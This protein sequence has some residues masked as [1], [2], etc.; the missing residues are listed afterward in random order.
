MKNSTVLGRAVSAGKFKLSAQG[1]YSCVAV[2]NYGNYTRIDFSVVFI[3][4]YCLVCDVVSFFYRIPLN[5]RTY[6]QSH[7]HRGTRGGG[8]D[9]IPLGFWYAAILPSVE[10]LWSSLQEEIYFMDGG[11]AEGLWRHQTWSPSWPPSWILSRIRNRVKTVWINNFLRL[12][13]KIT[14]KQLLCIVSSTSFTFEKSWKNMHF[15]SKMAWRLLLMTSYL[16]TIV[17]DRH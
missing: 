13:C 5:H 15:H 1:N 6:I 17:T 4:K 12:T 7:P 3:G 8:V 14:H 10:S 16:V 11:A 9:R 2:N